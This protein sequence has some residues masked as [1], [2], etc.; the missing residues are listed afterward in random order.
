MNEYEQL[1]AELRSLK[2]LPPGEA[3]SSKL[4]KAL[5]SAGNLAVRRLPDAEDSSADFLPSVPPESN[6]LPFTRLFFYTGC[7]GTGLAA[8]WALFFYLSNGLI[9]PSYVTEAE[10]P[11]FTDHFAAQVD[12]PVD[13]PE[14][15]VHGVT[16]GQLQDTSPMPVM[17]WSDP[18]NRERFL[19][20]VDEGIFQ[21]PSGVPARRVRHY[22]MDETLWSHPASD[23]RILS[24]SPR[25]EVIFIELDT[26]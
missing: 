23:M 2:P 4:E 16:L 22:Y 24:T 3:F 11:L 14:S 17:G 1:E 20:L 15:P 25:E 19:R 7:V 8:V 13:D 26:Y 10:Q 21:R 12:L 18:Q 6:P 9:A 5:G